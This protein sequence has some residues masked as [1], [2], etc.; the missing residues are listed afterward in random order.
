MGPIWALLTAA[1]ALAVVTAVSA[2]P[3]S[4]PVPDLDGYFARWQRLH[5]GYDPRTGSRWLHGWLALSYRVARPLAGRG[6]QPDVLTTWSVWL[7]VAV[8]VLA[9]AGGRWPVLAAWLL[10]ASGLGDTLD[11]AVAALTERATR[12]GYVLDSVVD[13]V[14]DVIYL[15]AVVAVGAPPALAVGCG[16]AFLLL[17][18]VRARSANAGGGEIGTVTVGERANR[19]IF[20]ALA[21][22]VT[23][24]VPARAAPLATAALAALTLL[25]AIGLV[26]L[27]I[28]VR[29]ELSVRP[30][31]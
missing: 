31:R 21:L 1:V 29:R 3:P 6:V 4:A 18:Y 11:G 17:E 14:N 25:S 7:A 23:G 22:L 2:R 26:Q 28:A 20:C 5:G 10:V 13:R 9:Q 19:V 16:L 30:G 12:W 27:L 24:A 15:L 8:L